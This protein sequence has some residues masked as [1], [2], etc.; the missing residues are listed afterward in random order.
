MAASSDD[1]GNE[2][3]GGG[4]QEE[5][6]RT[7]GWMT[8]YS[9]M[10]TLLLTFFV[11]MFALSNVDNERVELFLFAMSR[12]GLTA[13][14]FMEIR[15]RFELDERDGSEWD[16]LMPYPPPG[17]EEEPD[18][19]E[20]GETE[21][22]RALRELAEA[23][24]IYIDEEGLGGTVAVVFSGDFLM[25]TLTSDILFEPGRADVSPE[26]EETAYM[27][28]TLLGNNFNPADPFE[29][30]V[31]GHTDNVP[32]NP[33]NIL[34]PTNWHLSTGRAN[35]FL[36][37]LIES[38]GIDPPFFYTRGAGEFR[39]IASNDTPEG[40]QANRRVEV[41]ISLAR[42]NPLWEGGPTVDY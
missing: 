11:L 14:Q 37:L 19:G 9:D 4:E 40:R 12:D 33:N 42:A 27:L 2:R 20:V 3:S 34:F 15:Q 41:M 26:M 5:E 23:L 7:D 8:T 39:P 21:G 16:E 24:G 28:G 13:E 35:A 10:V 31:V 17:E 36:E 32:M 22:E 30:A 25:L 38:S 29:I 1:R 6:A 18:G